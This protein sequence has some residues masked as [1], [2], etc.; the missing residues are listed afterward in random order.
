[1]NA[2][3][4][5]VNSGDLDKDGYQHRIIDRLQILNDD[6]KNYSNKP[7]SFFSKVNDS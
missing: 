2:Y 7:K 6:L 4:S 3:L 1:M 5:A